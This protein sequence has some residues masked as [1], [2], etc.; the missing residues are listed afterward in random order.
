MRCMATSARMDYRPATAMGF[1]RQ[2]ARTGG[3]DM[4]GGEDFFADGRSYD[5]GMG[6]LSRI[7]GEQFLE[8]LA[9]PA[10]LHWLDVGCGSGSFTE[11][12]LRRGAPGAISA[13]DPSEGQIEF[14]KSKSSAQQI[15][16]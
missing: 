12:I 3:A 14:A 9:M 4:A 10:S 7:A 11:L 13:V 16:Y 2:H 15:D 8:W 5:R 6:R 1:S